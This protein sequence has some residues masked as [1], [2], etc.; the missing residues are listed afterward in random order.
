[1]LVVF[2]KT[3]HPI[4]IKYKFTRQNHA[5]IIHVKLKTIRFSSFFSINCGQTDILK[6]DNKCYVY[7]EL[8]THLKSKCALLLHI[9]VFILNVNQ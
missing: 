6:D 7:T 3:I 9:I 8:R 4:F 5:L 1:M 2:Y